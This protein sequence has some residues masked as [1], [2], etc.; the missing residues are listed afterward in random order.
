MLVSDSSV[1]VTLCSEACLS[2]TAKHAADKHQCRHSTAA[3]DGS[4]VRGAA[5]HPSRPIHRAL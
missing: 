2:W 4:V 1:E 3:E 5:S